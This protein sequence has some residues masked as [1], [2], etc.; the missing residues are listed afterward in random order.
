MT[1]ERNTSTRLN[2]GLH[3]FIY[4]ELQLIVFQFTE[5]VENVRIFILQIRPFI[6]RT[7]TKRVHGHAGVNTDY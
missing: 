1:A 7:W 6:A 5:S 3:R 2:Y 4:V